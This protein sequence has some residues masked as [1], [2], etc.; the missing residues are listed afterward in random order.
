MLAFI[1]ALNRDIWAPRPVGLILPNWPFRCDNEPR[2][3]ARLV[4]LQLSTFMSIVSYP[5]VRPSLFSLH[6]NLTPC[7]SLFTLCDV[8]LKIR[9]ATQTNASQLLLLRA[10]LAYQCMSEPRHFV[11]ARPNK[12]HSL[13]WT[14]YYGIW[15]MFAVSISTRKHLELSSIWILAGGFCDYENGLT[16]T[17]AKRKIHTDKKFNRTRAHGQSSTGKKR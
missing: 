3:E 12:V 5:L 1:S 15:R 17:V 6:L 4:V 9:K 7:P 14:C 8:S 2:K 10:R 11:R 16:L 13:C